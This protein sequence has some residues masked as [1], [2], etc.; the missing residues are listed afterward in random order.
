MKKDTFEEAWEWL[1]NHIN[2]SSAPRH[3]IS[4]DEAEECIVANPKFI[5]AVDAD[6]N[7][8]EGEDAWPEYASRG[9][10]DDDDDDAGAGD[11]DGRLQPRAKAMGKGK[12]KGKQKGKGKGKGGHDGGKGLSSPVSFAFVF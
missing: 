5:V 12:G 10:D 7:P 3:G 1:V 9:D 2:Q 8:M 6:G 11:G 4:R